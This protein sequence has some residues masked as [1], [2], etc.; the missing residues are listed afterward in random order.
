MDLFAAHRYSSHLIG[1]SAAQRDVINLTYLESAL[2]AGRADVAEA[3][4]AERRLFKPDS[5]FTDFI[6]SRLLT[7][8]EAASLT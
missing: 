7:P 6:R 4:M 1:G 2:R 5:P 3:L 8:G